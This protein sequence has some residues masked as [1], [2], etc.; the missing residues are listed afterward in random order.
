MPHFLSDVSVFTYNKYEQDMP[1]IYTVGL[2]PN[3]SYIQR[4]SNSSFCKGPL[5]LNITPTFILY[6]P[7]YIGFILSLMMS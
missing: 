6:K 4:S 5:I 2:L 3:V 1:V 7:N